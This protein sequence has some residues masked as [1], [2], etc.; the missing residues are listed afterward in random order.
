M[1][2]SF[3]YR[4]ENVIVGTCKKNKSRE[5]V[6]SITHAFDEDVSSAEIRFEV[7]KGKI[8]IPTLSCI[9]TP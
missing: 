9:L 8:R 4:G 7:G 2:L 1:Q 6:L 5:C 3:L